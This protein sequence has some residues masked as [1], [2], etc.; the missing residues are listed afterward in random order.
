MDKLNDIL[1]NPQFRRCLKIISNHEKN[2]IFCK[3]GTPH[4][5]SVA[6]IALKLNKLEGLNIDPEII[7][8]AAYLHDIGRSDTKSGVPHAHASVK[9]A[10][11]IL[12]QADFSEDEITLII[13]AIRHHS[14]QE[15]ASAEGLVRILYLADV[16]SRNCSICKAKAKC[17][18]HLS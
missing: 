5:E 4:L 8:A 13:K 6:N 10:K 9:L 7:Y 1:N 12:E 16:K 2:R 17:K 14:E 18:N 15:S 3:H 11:P